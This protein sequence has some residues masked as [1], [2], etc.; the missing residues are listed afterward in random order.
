MRNGCVPILYNFFNTNQVVF[1]TNQ[2]LLQSSLVALV[3]VVCVLIVEEGIARG[4]SVRTGLPHTRGGGI[5]C[6]EEGT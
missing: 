6:V 5:G 3:A 1:S 4:L 2:G